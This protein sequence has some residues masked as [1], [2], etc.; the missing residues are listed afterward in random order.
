MALT[1]QDISETVELAVLKAIEPLS[2]KVTEHEQTL[3]G[4]TGNNG[5]RSKVRVLERFAWTVTGGIL[6]AGAILGTIQIIR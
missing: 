2:Q 1:K 4:K 5:L 6:L 3:H